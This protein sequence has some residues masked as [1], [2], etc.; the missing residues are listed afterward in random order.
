MRVPADTRTQYKN[1]SVFHDITVGS[2][3]GCGTDGFAVA[4]G[5]DPVT[6]LRTPNYPALLKLFTG[7]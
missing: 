3:P 4:K 1:P 5:W 7:Q 2:N 6:G